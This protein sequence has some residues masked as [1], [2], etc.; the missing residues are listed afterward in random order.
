MDAANYVAD[1]DMHAFQEACP[2]MF[3]MATGEYRHP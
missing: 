1:R 3:F 2:M